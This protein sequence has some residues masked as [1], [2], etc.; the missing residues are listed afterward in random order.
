MV[1]YLFYRYK[2]HNTVILK[3]MTTA[4]N[5]YN[6]LKDVFVPYRNL[7]SAKESSAKFIRKQLKTA[8]KLVKATKKPI[9]K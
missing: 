3:L 6:S 9:A 1:F 5:E 7:K 4:W 8:E 2:Y